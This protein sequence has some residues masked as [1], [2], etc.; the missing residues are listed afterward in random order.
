MP[1]GLVFSAMAQSPDEKGVLVFGGESDKH[2]PMDKILELRAGA[3]SWNIL[4][5]TLKIARSE[6]VVIPLQ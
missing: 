3:T 1:Y 2:Y 5:I 6:H 4:D